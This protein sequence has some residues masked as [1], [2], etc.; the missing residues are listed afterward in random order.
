[1][2]LPIWFYQN[3][4]NRW[5]SECLLVLIVELVSFYPTMCSLIHVPVTYTAGKYNKLGYAQ[6]MSSR[7]VT[8]NVHSKH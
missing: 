3:C 4:M 5:T 7:F 6:S 2:S 1:M 8:K